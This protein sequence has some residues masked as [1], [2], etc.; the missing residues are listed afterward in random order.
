MVHSHKHFEQYLNEKVF[1]DEDHQERLN[2]LYK[3]Y[4]LS[5]TEDRFDFNNPSSNNPTSNIM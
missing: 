3:G 5:E 4:N 1:K 2:A